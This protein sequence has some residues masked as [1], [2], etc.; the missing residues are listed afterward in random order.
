MINYHDEILIILN[1][2][3]VIFNIVNLLNNYFHEQFPN[4]C[5]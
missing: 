3:I 1:N 2:R 4:E 5:N